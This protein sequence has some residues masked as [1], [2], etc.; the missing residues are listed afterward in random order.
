MGSTHHCHRLGPLWQSGAATEGSG[1]SWG[2]KGKWE[3]ED[4]RVKSEESKGGNCTK[5][6]D[7]NDSL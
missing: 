3:K 6:L 2:S 4:G 5:H 7:W 1:V